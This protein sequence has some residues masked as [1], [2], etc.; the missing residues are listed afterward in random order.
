M[1]KEVLAVMRSRLRA[2]LV[3]GG[4]GLI[5][6]SLAACGDGMDEVPAASSPEVKD[7]IG[8]LKVGM[9]HSSFNDEI[10][11][12]MLNSFDLAIKHLNEAGGVF[13]QPVQVEIVEATTDPDLAVQRALEMIEDGPPH[14]IVGGWTSGTALPITEEVIAPVG[15]PMVSPSA[16]SPLLSTAS[17][18]DFFFRTIPVDSAGAPVLADLVRERGFTN[19]GVIYREDPWGSKYAEAFEAAW[20]GSIRLVGIEPGQSSYLSE[21]QESAVE[22]AEALVPITF[23]A[24]G[25]I[26]LR[27]ALDNGIYDQ[28][29]LTGPMKDLRTIQEI[30]RDGLGG[31]HGIAAVADRASA[32]SVAWEEAYIAEYGDLSVLAYVKETYDATI[33]LALA[34]EAAGSTDGAAIRDQLRRVTDGNGEVAIAGP[35]GVARALETLASGGE[36]NYE[37]A[38]TSLDWDESGDLLRG[39]I[40]VWRFSEQGDIEEVKVVPFGN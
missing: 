6:A 7:S 2:F 20:E 23:N 1:K 12:G 9:L 18:R 10:R 25:L 3:L 36:I 24:E 5:L 37:G 22:G 26:L 4:I 32:S 28:F 17:D 31:M 21:L 39:Y 19:I 35:E 11:D 8:P 34:A 29:V 40:G 15:I 16:T 14:V 30:G 33:A 13:G 27:E 38:S